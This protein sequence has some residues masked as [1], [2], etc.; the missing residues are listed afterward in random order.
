MVAQFSTGILAH[1]SISI[2]SE[3]GLR[4]QKI[5]R[6]TY[7]K[8]S[9]V[10]EFISRNMEEV[11]LDGKKVL[12]VKEGTGKKAPGKTAKGKKGGRRNTGTDKRT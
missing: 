2:Y 10:L 3:Y 9:D 7:Y 6:K 1:F 8:E 12:K 5:S 4:Y 11:T